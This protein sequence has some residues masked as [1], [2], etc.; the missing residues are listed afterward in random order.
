MT[1]SALREPA[2]LRSMAP[3]GQTYQHS[4]LGDIVRQVYGDGKPDVI[5]SYFTPN[6][7]VG[8]VYIKHYGIPERL[9]RFPTEFSKVD[10]PKVFAL[11]DFWA[12]KPKQFSNHLG[13]LEFS[14]L[15]SC[16]TPPYASE[17]DFYAFF[18]QK[19]RDN[20]EFIA[21]PRCVEETCFRD[22]GLDKNVDVITLGAM[23]NFY[24]FRRHMHRTLSTSHKSMGVSYKNYK[25]C[26]TNFNHGSFVRDEYAKAISQA[27][28]LVSCGGRYHLAFN[29]IFES[30]GCGTLYVG[31]K[32]YG[33]KELH[34]EDG[35]NYVAV[36]KSNFLEKIK[37]YSENDA[38]RERI[39]KNA[40]ETFKNHHTI[41][42][43]AK[44]FATRVESIL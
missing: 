18:D 27:K 9:H 41:D 26:G 17:K 44:E 39:V 35:V 14:H 25:H 42:A 19:L 29:K 28:M 43:R 21:H 10:V 32:P 40:K 1:W 20:M 23:S 15:F 4:D 37:Y 11:S 12:R 38:E 13:G 36:T 30:M 8:D 7:R 34:M 5:Y 31:E 24:S 6:E 2:I 22:Y 16:F 33:E 3:D